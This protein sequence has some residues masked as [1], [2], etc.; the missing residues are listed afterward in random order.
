MALFSSCSDDAVAVRQ[1][2]VDTDPL[3]IKAEFGKNLVG[4]V[5]VDGRARQG[6]VVSDG[7]NVVTTDAK[8]EY[9]MYTTGRQHV[10]ISVPEDCEIPVYNGLPKFYK[11]LNFDDAAIIQRDFPLVSSPK[12]SEWTLFTMADPQIGGDADFTEFTGML[13]RM[14]EFTST[15][16]GAVYGI[17]LGDIVWN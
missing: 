16:P 17:D 10:F 8:G 4:R 13:P 6:V 5:T 2:G 14:S 3:T 12:K 15:M 11:T 9:Q 1:Q 7:V